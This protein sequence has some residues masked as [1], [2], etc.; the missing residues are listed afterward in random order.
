M[1]PYLPRIIQDAER[2]AELLEVNQVLDSQS[3]QYGGFVD[4]KHWTQPKTTIYKL[5]TLL[6]LY[7][8]P[9]SRYYQSAEAM[10]KIQNALDYVI[11]FQHQDGTFDYINCNF[12]SAPDT[13]F[14]VKR[15]LPSWLYLEKDRSDA[16]NKEAFEKISGI[17][18]RAAEGI[19]LGGFHT[20]N[21][22]W[23]IA[24]VLMACANRFHEEKFRA[25]A[26]EY[27]REGIDCNQYGEFSER[28]SG[29]YNRIN[30]EAMILLYEETGD[31]S[32]LDYAV[33]N[34][35]MMLS[36]F[37]PDGSI[38]TKNSVRYDSW[39]RVYPKDYYFDYLYL[40]HETNNPVFAAASNQIMEDLLTRGDRTPDCLNRFLI[41]PE[42][43]EY[44]PKGC[45]F[46]EKYRLVNPDSGIV[47]VRKGS[48]SYTLL[49][50]TP[51]FLYFQSG[52][53]SVCARFGITYFDKR[54]FQPDEILPEENGYT[55]SQT[56]RGWYYAPFCGKPATSDWWKMDNASR[57]IV[58]GPDLSIRLSISEEDDGINLQIHTE[59]CG[60]VPYK[61]EF[62]V[63]NGCF[64]RTNGFFCMAQP[65]EKIVARTGSA[66]LSKGVDCIKIGPCFGKHFHIEGKDGAKDTDDTL[67]HIYFTGFTG[68]DQLLRF[69][70]LSNR[71]AAP[72]SL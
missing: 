41:H 68:P 72:N 15:L 58:A 71:F 69:Q 70:K 65:G 18:R 9:Q 29:N 27:L 3:E 45:G 24:S 55:L 44:E 54:S 23:A 2:R 35:K 37:E 26:E 67:F 17:L 21:H 64:V 20:P 4:E 40:A 30:D 7:N 16:G 1:N 66:E 19:R 10:Q 6:S 56:M 28:S 33:R 50:K 32:Y 11:R 53:L 59:G 62:G 13:A 25:R 43:V 63:E 52:G 5:T 60:H 22:R 57:E 36:Y 14:C 8:T 51:Y 31:R 42:L 38:F 34:M 61:I 39:K 12:H 46:P 47:R 48:V 49:S